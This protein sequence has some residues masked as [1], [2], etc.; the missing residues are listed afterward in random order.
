MA[1]A[2]GS[3]HRGGGRDGALGE[4]APTVEGGRMRATA[5][6][7]GFAAVLS[8][9][10]LGTRP[11]DGAVGGAAGPLS[12]SARPAIASPL[13]LEENLGQ[14]ARGVAFLARQRGF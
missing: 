5:L 12:R 7:A 2:A 3:Q 13:V 1:D 9:V 10:A 4:N 14:T 8:A 6:L 11:V